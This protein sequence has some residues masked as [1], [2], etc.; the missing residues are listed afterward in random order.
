MAFQLWLL[1]TFVV[2]I[3]I[4]MTSFSTELEMVK[5][6]I[7]SKTKFAYDQLMAKSSPLAADVKTRF[8]ASFTQFSNGIKAVW[9]DVL[10][11]PVVQTLS[12]YV[13][14]AWDYGNDVFQHLSHKLHTSF[15]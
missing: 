12:Q 14:Q 3:T 11:L 8:A 1:V 13:L 10:Q 7:F 2:A 15:A 9:H 6:E 5:E 4:I